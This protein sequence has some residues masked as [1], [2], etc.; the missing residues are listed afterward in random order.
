MPPS[1]VAGVVRKLYPIRIA[2]AMFWLLLMISLAIAGGLLNRARGGMLSFTQYSYW[3][4]HIR[5]RL[6][7]AGP[8][9]A[10]VVGSETFNVTISY[11][12]FTAADVSS[13]AGITHYISDDL[14]QFIHRLGHVF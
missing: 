9:G 11:H 3:S 7:M 2:S 6:L 10:L 14:V 5:S 13:H 12:Q 8:T 4:A 1:G